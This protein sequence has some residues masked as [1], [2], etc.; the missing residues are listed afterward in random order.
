MGFVK[1]LIFFVTVQN[2]WKSVHIWESYHRL[3]NV[4][5]LWTTMCNW[6]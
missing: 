3:C 5:F 6:Y 2:S 1:N 4:M